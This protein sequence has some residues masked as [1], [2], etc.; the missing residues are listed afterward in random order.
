MLSDGREPKMEDDY[1]WLEGGM[2]QL[3]AQARKVLRLRYGG[4]DLRSLSQVAHCMGLTKSTVQGL[5]QRALRQLRASLHPRV[6]QEL[7]SSLSA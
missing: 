7:A 5:E 3:N 1:R 4:E 6:K 2:A